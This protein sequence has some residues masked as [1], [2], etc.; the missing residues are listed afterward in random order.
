MQLGTK[1]LIT[2]SSTFVALTIALFFISQVFLLGSFKEYEEKDTA[3]NVVRVMNALQG[4][5]D[6]LHSLNLDW[7]SWDDSY[8]FIKD[9]N[10]GFIRSNLNNETLAKQRLALIIFL[11][12]SNRIVFS[13]SLDHYSIRDTA[14]PEDFRPLIAQRGQISAARQHG[15]GQSGIVKVGS[16]PMAIS[17]RPILTSEGTGP[18]RGALIMGRYLDD[19]ELLRLSAE[20]RLPVELLDYESGLFESVG[21]DVARPLAGKDGIMTRVYSGGKILGYGVIKDISDAPAFV[22]KIELPRDIYRQGQTSLTYFI[23]YLLLAALV[24]AAVTIALIRKTVISRISR[25]SRAAGEVGR[26]GDL[27]LRVDAGGGDEISALSGEVNRMLCSLEAF[28]AE[29]KGSEEKTRK[30]NDELE[31]RVKERTAELLKKNAELNDE[32][33]ERKRVEEAMK[34]MVYHDYLTGLP[35]RMLFT[36]RLNQLIARSHRKGGIIAA[37]V[38][39]GIDR[40][41]VVNN[42]LGHAAGDE[43][44]KRIGSIVQSTLRETDTVARVG[45]DEF[46]LLLADLPVIERIP[47]VLERVMTFLRMPVE[48]MG[49]SLFVTASMGVA[50][51]PHDGADSTTLL[52]NAE[53]AMHFAKTKGGNAFEM[54]DPEMARKAFERLTIGNRLRIALDREEFVMHY[55][56]LYDLREKRFTGAE[57]LIRW[58]DPE[59]AGLVPPMSFIPIAEETGVITPIGE[60][61]LLKACSFAKKMQDSGFGHISMSVN[62]S[63][64]MFEEEDFAE[65][66]TDILKASG[67][68]P[69]DLNLE[70]TESLLMAHLEEAARKIKEIKGAGIKFSIDDFGTGYS[71]LAYLQNLSIDEI[72]IDRSFVM[73]LPSDR[74]IVKAIINLAHNLN[75]DV[76]AEGVETQEQLDFLVEHKCDKIQGFLFARPMPEEEFLCLMKE[77]SRKTAAR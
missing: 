33:A 1:T 52:K 56:P 4:E 67:L 8:E 47:S 23:A 63:P 26:T 29:R 35:N 75:L 71:S 68:R 15:A 19:E 74:F 5:I 73:G 54:Y 18:V 36:D 30:A 55:Q 59:A 48:L 57:A 12:S 25:L 53:A 76:I 61:G 46:A 38:V 77:N 10:A 64:R 69:R 14:F 16:R 60:W 43:L 7:A 27:S 22:L 65:N 28:E 37:V 34:E 58:K 44:I 70:I 39:M 49:H 66:V 20:T 32:I 51:F 11:D 42:S 3:L 40:F 62:I 2:I 9:R 50:V 24:S 21:R 41:R 6:N 45:G 13:R 31:A 72:K 17:S